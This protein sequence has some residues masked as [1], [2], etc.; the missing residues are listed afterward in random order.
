MYPGK[1]EL[2][3]AFSL[4][5]QGDVGDAR[6]RLRDIVKR[7]PGILLAWKTLADI[8]DN[9]RE[10]ADAI[11][12]AQLLAPGDAWVLEA[13]KHR[14]P[15]RDAPH[16][17]P[18]TSGPYALAPE[19][20]GDS[21]P[22]FEPVG[23]TPASSGYGQSQEP[24]RPSG[25]GRFTSNLFGRGRAETTQPGRIAPPPP[26]AAP[27][28]VSPDEA[29]IERPLS[30]DEHD[31]LAP[32]APRPAT[33][34]PF[35]APPP[36]PLPSDTTIT[37]GT[38]PLP[39]VED[40]LPPPPPV[41]PKAIPMTDAP[42]AASPPDTP[43]PA[44]KAVQVPPPTPPP[45][46][47]T[48]SRPRLTAEERARILAEADDKPAAATTPRSVVR[49]LSPDEAPPVEPPVFSEPPPDDDATQAS[50]RV[51]RK[52][53]QY[54]EELAPDPI[55]VPVQTPPVVPQRRGQDTGFDAEAAL[56]EDASGRFRIDEL[57]PPERPQVNDDSSDPLP[58]WMI[59]IVV[60]AALGG[61]LLLLAAAM[62][63][64]FIG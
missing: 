63:G 22:A 62:T 52:L 34:N 42:P 49:P 16:A 5:A 36:T 33:R 46:D 57:L 18:P 21:G 64:G 28:V 35:E 17:T 59:A 14:M 38:P 3:E 55:P 4:L 48:Q 61:V 10:R 15:P 54:A 6:Q 12:R 53:D 45:G 56:G 23:L 30:D 50:V 44:P 7:R 8:A 31:T 58:L 25:L 60:M 20:E 1:D 19:A 32:E 27:P 2:R 37:R 43:P 51:Q 29:T 41:P 40:I 47:V 9:P 26:P 13:R 39:D 24:D 11:R